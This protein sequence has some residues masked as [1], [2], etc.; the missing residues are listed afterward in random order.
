MRFSVLSCAAAL[1]TCLLASC[2]S[3][4]AQHVRA[5]LGSVAIGGNVTGSTINIGVPVEKIE[6]L[7]KERTKPLEELTSSQKD[8]ISL[9]KDKLDLNERQIRTALEIIGEKDIPREQLTAKLAEV[10]ERYKELLASAASQPG[11]TPAITARK[12]E[13]EKA[14]DAGELAKADELLAAVEAEQRE[15]LDRITLNAAETL[16]RRG[17]IAMTRLRYQ[18]AAKH[19]AAAAAL[20]PAGGPREDERIDYLEREAGALFQYGH[21]FGDRGALRSVIERSRTLIALQP[22]DRA[23][24]KWAEAQYLLGITFADLGHYGKGKMRYAAAVTA[25][26]EAQKEFT[27]ERSPLDWARMEDARALALGL[28]GAR[29]RGTARLD[30]AVA[31]YRAILKILPREEEPLQWALAQ[32]RLG[33]MLRLRGLRDRGTTCF[34]RRSRRTVRHSRSSPARLCRSRGPRR[35]TT[36]G[37]RSIAS[38]Y[39][40]AAPPG[41]KRPLPPFARR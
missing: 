16:G 20:F 34:M 29:E 14:I 27:R 18:E 17:D 21:A 38:D 41:S 15:A 24:L 25:Y 40:R 26:E 22:R 9:L 6:A 35:S 28:L 1:G 12:A 31:A 33:V 13:A 3:A 36:W 39:A 10:A 7:V 4:S 23:P 11:D 2:P 5:D 30:E 8:T 32:Q 19:F 37:S